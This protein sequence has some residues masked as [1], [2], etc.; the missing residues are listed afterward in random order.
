[1]Y[2]MKDGKLKTPPSL[3]LTRH[4]RKGESHA[5]SKNIN[6]FQKFR[7]GGEKWVDLK[8][9]EARKPIYLSKT[10]EYTTSKE[11]VAYN[12]G[13]VVKMC[14]RELEVAQ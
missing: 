4:F 6:D 12:L 11:K 5:D 13:L 1:M 7:K 14:K 2:L 9:L 3:I 8:N 10:T